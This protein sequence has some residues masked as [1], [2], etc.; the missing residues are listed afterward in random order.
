[1]KVILIVIGALILILG[2]F[3]LFRDSHVW[4]NTRV[5]FS[6]NFGRNYLCKCGHKAKW[7]TRLFIGGSQGIYT[8][9]KD[10][11]YCPE[12]F[13]KAAIKCAWCGKPIMP[14]DPITLYT[15][16]K[17]D[18][19]VPKH[20]VVWETDPLQL[21]GCLRWGCAESGADRSGF[22]EMPGRVQ[23]VASPIE[24]L[25]A[26]GPEGGPIIINDLSDPCEAIPIPDKSA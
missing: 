11:D 25:L 4:D 19:E 3:F 12:C 5:F 6:K 9:H 14:G 10:T 22:W 18:F 13:S 7:K 20:A 23:R 26:R 21:V 15:P 1:M 24:M 2:L 16:R 8:L 17:N